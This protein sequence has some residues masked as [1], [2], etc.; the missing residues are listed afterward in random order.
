MCAAAFSNFHTNMLNYQTVLGELAADKGLEF[1]DQENDLETLLKNIVNLNKDTLSYVNVL[2]YNI[3]AL[4][5][6]LGPSMCF[7]S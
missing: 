3:P 1:Y 4:G 2:T 6:I 7:L 5:P